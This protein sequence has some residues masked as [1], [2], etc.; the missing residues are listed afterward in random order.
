MPWTDTKNT[1]GDF[2][3]LGFGV[4]FERKTDRNRTERVAKTKWCSELVR[5]QRV[6]EIMI[7]KRK[8]YLNNTVSV[9]YLKDK[10]D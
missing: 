2:V 5:S 7:I 3:G 6:Y 1:L 9:K 10:V 4:F 8:F